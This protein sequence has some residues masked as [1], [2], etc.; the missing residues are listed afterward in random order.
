MENKII[1]NDSSSKLNI[2]NFYLLFSNMNE[3]KQ[4]LNSY[5]QFINKYYGILI[6]YYKQL[7][8]LNCKFLIKDR[9][10][11]S[12]I[13]SPIFQ[14]G[15]LIKKIVEAQINSL[16]SIVIKENIFDEFNNSL[17]NLFKILQE[18]SKKMEDEFFENSIR[19]I[20]NSLFETYSQIESKVIDNYIRKK[21]NKQ[22][23]GLNAD[24]L[25]TNIEQAKYLEKTFFDFEKESKITFFDDLNQM[26]Y[27]TIK[28]FYGMKNTVERYID[29]LK[30]KDNEYLNILQKEMIGVEKK[31][32][33][34][35]KD[36]SHSHDE[37]KLKNNNAKD[38]FEYKI[39]IIYQPIIRVEAQN[40]KENN[41]E[42]TNNKSSEKETVIKNNE[43]TLKDVDIFNI[44]STLYSYDLK[45]L[46]KSEYNLNKE[47][48]K[49][50]LIKLSEKLISNEK[51][52]EIITDEEVNELYNLLNDQENYFRFFLILNNFRTTGQ[53]EMSERIFNIIKIIFN[54]SLDYL[55]IKKDR[56][57]KDLIIILSQ[58]FY[59]IK[60][61]ERIFFQKVIKDHD[62]FKK[63]EFWANHLKDIINEDINR[64][65]TDIK[66]ELIVF[67]KEDKERK[68]KDIII[69]KLI[70]I[71]LSMKGFDVPKE[72]I[73]YIINPF[74]YKY[75]L[76]E[77]S[78]KAL[79]S[80]LEQ[81]Q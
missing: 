66:N 80:L 72:M 15:Q 81:K 17:S 64:L 32:D 9:F 76:E 58:T 16:F 12:L 1:I 71:S 56:K 31:F 57:L 4:L 42:I 40:E 63:K 51:E 45:M 48:E 3:S 77:N 35:N 46:N 19:Q 59:T 50:K 68:I 28:A 41:E 24:T 43:L 7:M 62:L 60:E 29:I 6:D 36:E 23:V 2:S 20:A 44:V 11:S 30:K 61:G 22:L 74:I 39:K 21:Y 26:E 25:E 67:S 34:D 70:P 33:L 75:N 47:K 55:L 37:L 79:L 13:N 38:N 73:L 78:K 18:S 10:K 14:I 65:E 52:N 49:F 69:S 53:F 27:K 5:K 54:K 8:E